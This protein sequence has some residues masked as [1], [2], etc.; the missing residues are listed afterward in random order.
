MQYMPR[1]LKN[2]LS[3]ALKP[4]G[5][6]MYIWGGGWNE[7]NTGAG[8]DAMR[9]GVSPKW[10]EFFECQT[11]K[12]DF[13]NYLNLRHCG[14]DCSGY[15]GWVMYNYI[16]CSGIKTDNCGYVFKAGSQA[17]R[18][19]DMGFGSFTKNTEVKDYMPGDIMSSSNH[20]YIV[21]GSCEDGSLVLLHSSPPGV[22]ICGTCSA[23]GSR[24]SSGVYLARAYMNAYYNEWYQK[25][26]YRIR[27]TSY[28]TEYSQFRWN[29]NDK[30]IM[31]DPDGLLYMS[32]SEVLASLFDDKSTA[33]YL[34]RP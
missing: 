20:V 13:K 29:S 9:I 26:G 10:K 2:F 18:F 30:S 1:T 27:D 7:E 23:D 15:V 12:Y 34:K 31:C 28:L 21:I 5:S 25:F 11:S 16:K 17:E 32:T 22:Q 8:K 3:I 14:L 24:F 33:N 6:T 4:V 19:A